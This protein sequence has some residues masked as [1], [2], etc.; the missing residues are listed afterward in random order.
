[1]IS[2]GVRLIVWINRPSAQKKVRKSNSIKL[3]AQSGGIRPAS[4]QSAMRP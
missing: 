4:K 2:N 1:M 3:A